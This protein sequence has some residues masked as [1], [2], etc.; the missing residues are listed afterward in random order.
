VRS[1]YL[2]WGTS[3]YVLG[4]VGLVS[5]RRLLYQSKPSIEDHNA[6]TDLNG[7]S[8]PELHGSTTAS[9]HPLSGA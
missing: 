7:D 2:G 4:L 1:A 3:S 6:N 8:M 9:W 5:A